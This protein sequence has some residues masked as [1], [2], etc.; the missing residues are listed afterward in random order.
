VE[1]RL[2]LDGIPSSNRKAVIQVTGGKY[3]DCI[4]GKRIFDAFLE[5]VIKA[6]GDDWAHLTVDT[7][8]LHSPVAKVWASLKDEEEEREYQAEIDEEAA[9]GIEC[10]IVCTDEDMEDFFGQIQKM[11]QEHMMA[12]GPPSASARM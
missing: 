12:T 6:L 5:N 11:R 1:C 8:D 4:F 2:W 9:A 7:K 10:P 3:D